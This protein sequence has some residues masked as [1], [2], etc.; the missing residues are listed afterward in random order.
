MSDAS[1]WSCPRKRHAGLWNTPQ[2][3]SLLADDLMTLSEAR[4]HTGDIIVLQTPPEDSVRNATLS[5][6]MTTYQPRHG[7]RETAGRLPRREEDA[8]A[9]DELQDEVRCIVFLHAL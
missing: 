5:S 1:C 2:S 3:C 4:V 8:G 7:A 9:G 6:S